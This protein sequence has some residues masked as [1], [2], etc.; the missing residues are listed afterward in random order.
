V[1]IQFYFINKTSINQKTPRACLRT[2]SR[3]E[4]VIILGEK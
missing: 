1:D 2:V 3:N 4:S